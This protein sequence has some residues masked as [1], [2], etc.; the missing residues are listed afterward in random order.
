MISTRYGI[1]T[2]RQT[3]HIA[4]ELIFQENKTLPAGTG[5]FPSGREL[6]ADIV[7]HKNK[8]VFQANEIQAFVLVEHTGLEPVTPT[9]PVWYAPNCANAPL[10]TLYY[11]REQK[12]IVEINLI[13][14]T[15]CSCSPKILMA[16]IM[17][18]HS[19]RFFSS[20]HESLCAV[21]ISPMYW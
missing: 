7:P 21:W 6:F 12:S 16:F 13:D 11:I 18:A 2:L 8:P 4:D 1:C 17:I 15:Y 20:W 3:L 19:R 14:I 10:G 5:N 9:L